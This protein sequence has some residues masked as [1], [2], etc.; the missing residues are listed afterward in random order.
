[1]ERR[2]INK[3]ILAAERRLALKER[4]VKSYT[5]FAAMHK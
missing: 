5:N 3:G 4:L 1:M 2:A